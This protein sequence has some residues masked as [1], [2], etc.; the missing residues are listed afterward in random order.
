MNGR[1]ATCT[2]LF[3][4]VHTSR[5]LSATC[6][7]RRLSPISGQK[8]DLG[9]A[10]ALHTSGHQECVYQCLGL[11]SKCVSMSYNAVDK[12]CSIS[13]TP[14]LVLSP[15][16]DVRT[17]VFHDLIHDLSQCLQWSPYHGISHERSIVYDVGSSG[18]IWLVRWNDLQGNVLIGYMLKGYDWHTGFFKYIDKTSIRSPFTGCDLAIIANDCSVAWVRFTIGEPVPS[19]AAKAGYITGHGP[20]L[21]ARYIDPTRQTYRL[22]YYMTGNRFVNHMSDDIYNINTFDILLAV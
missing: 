12:L 2:I 8:C 7:Q 13:A 19:N 4:I 9:Q 15:Q 10:E 17:N 22:G 14:C 18:T 11:G 5:G 6:G 3:H 21:V 16:P 20:V 1:V